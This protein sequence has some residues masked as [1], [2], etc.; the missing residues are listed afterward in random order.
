MK[1]LSGAAM[2]A[3]SRSPLP[4]AVLV[5]MDL[6]APLFLNTGG[7]DLVVG[8]STYYGTKGLGKI[9]PVQDSA[10][11]IKPMRFEL[12]GV[13]PEMIALA[14]AEPVQGKAVRV[15]MAIFDPD[16]YQVLDVRLR[17]AGKIDLFQIKDGADGKAILSCTAEHEGIHLVRPIVSYFSHSEQQRLH[18]GDLAFQYQA[19]QFEQKILWPDRYF[20]RKQ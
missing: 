11:E 2:A 4:L 18:S 20:G 9:E 19:D 8:G 13:G 6:T 1:I 15:K 14:L 10:A 16:T 3:L 17:W 12:S 5:E 7:I